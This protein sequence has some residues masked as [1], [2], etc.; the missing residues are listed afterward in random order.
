[1]RRLLMA[2]EW[3]PIDCNLG[4]KPE[5]LEVAATTHEPIEVVVGRMVRLWSWAWHVTADGTIRVPRSMLATVAGGDETFWAAVERAGWLASTADTVTI[6]GW[7]E[8]FGNAAKRR[9][10]DARQKSV[11]RLS[12]RDE[13]VLRTARGLEERRGEE[14]REEL[15]PAAPV[16]TTEPATP[17]RSRA[18]SLVSW[19]ADAGW[20]GITDADRQGWATAY[21]G[22]VLEQELAKASEW[23][24]ANPKR[25]GKRNWRAFLVR[26]LQRC[27]DHGGTTR[28]VG[29][30]PED[31]PPPKVWKD[32]YRPAAYRRPHEVAAVASTLKL[33]EEDL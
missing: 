11:R 17:S 25:A 27:Q 19:A 31:K 32:Q 18:K 10:L 28:D 22:A 14:K 15:Q 8:R 20:S 16:P 21:P 24:K 4:T 5:V 30:R 26:W 33:K 12:A 9:L 6:P 7:E 23:L 1:L 13:D 29:R 2:G 3:I